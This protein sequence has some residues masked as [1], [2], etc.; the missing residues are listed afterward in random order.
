MNNLSRRGVATA[1]TVLATAAVSLTWAASSASAAT[2]M[3]NGP[4]PACSAN[5]LE[6]RVGSVHG[7]PHSHDVTYSLD[8]SNTSRYACTLRGYPENV[9]AADYRGHRIGLPAARIPGAP[10]SPVVLMQG[11]T[12]HSRLVYNPDAL[13]AHGC[14]PTYS[15]LLVAGLP[16]SGQPA[17]ANFSQEVC[18]G[19]VVDLSIGQLQQGA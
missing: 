8:F 12:A 13:R 6:V 15:A 7:T 19:H 17:R 4:F 9:G 2:A 11:Q 18:S 3:H 1:A 16:E 10:S 14:R 5:N